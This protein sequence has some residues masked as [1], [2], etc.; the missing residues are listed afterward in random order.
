MEENKKKP[1]T[2]V[3]NEAKEKG[4]LDDFIFAEQD[5]KKCSE[6]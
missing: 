1:S 3:N 4:D 2:I 5:N 6:K